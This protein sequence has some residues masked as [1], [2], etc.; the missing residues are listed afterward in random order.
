LSC[1]RRRSR[2]GGNAEGA[3]TAA[4]AANGAFVRAHR[5]LRA[6]G[7]SLGR[8]S[9]THRAEAVAEGCG[10]IGEGDGVGR[11]GGAS[12]I[13]IG[14]LVHIHWAASADGAIQ[15]RVP[16][17]KYKFWEE[18]MA[19]QRNGSDHAIAPRIARAGKRAG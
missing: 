14:G 11:A 15:P 8:T 17:V 10:R 1:G 12:S 4:R 19:N 2:G 13:A 18:K 9:V 6:R 7:A 5:A 16:E 3:A